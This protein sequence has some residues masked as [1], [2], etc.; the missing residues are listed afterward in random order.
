MPTIDTHLVNLFGGPGAGK[1]TRAAELL[2]WMK[3]H[4]LNVEYVPE[5]AKELVWQ[6]AK[7]IDDQIYILGVQHHRLY[8]LLG[9][10]DWIITDSPLLLS[11]HYMLEN[12][13]G[14]DGTPE[15]EGIRDL[16]ARLALMLHQNWTNRHNLVV[17]RGER[18]FVQAGRMQDERQSREIDRR[19]TETLNTIGESFEVVE[20]GRQVI[21]A[22]RRQ[23]GLM[24]RS[25][26]A[27]RNFI[28]ASVKSVV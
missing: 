8:T 27:T 23:L 4:R 18:L 1:S 16:G 14:Y 11:T 19:L 28:A 17:E 21:E 20:D 22:L 2:G 5:F 3:H 26:R 12:L 25:D 6:E 24:G 15:I 13:R 9:K 10:V 7:C